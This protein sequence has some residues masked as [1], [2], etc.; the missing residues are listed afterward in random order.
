MWNRNILHLM[1]IASNG[2]ASAHA[3][4]CDLPN[5]NQ[6]TV[7]ANRLELNRLEARLQG[8]DHLCSDLISDR[9]VNNSCIV[10]LPQPGLLVV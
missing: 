7:V 8:I 2:R 1:G 10:G 5:P 9:Q 4:R 3:L 6:Y